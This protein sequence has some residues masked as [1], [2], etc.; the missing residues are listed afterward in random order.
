[1]TLRRRITVTVLGVVFVTLAAFATPLWVGYSRIY[2]DEEVLRLQRE[3][4][5]A[6]VTVPEELGSVPVE[7]P[8]PPEEITTA[9][10]DLEGQRVAGDGPTSGGSLVAQAARGEAVD[11]TSQ[12]ELVVAAPIYDDEEVIAVVRAAQPSHS[13]VEEV[14]EAR[15][16]ITVLGL[17]IVAGAAAVGIFLARRLARPVEALTAAATR[18]GDGDFATTA[19]HSGIRELDDAAQALDRTARRLG[20]IL[21]RERRFSADASHQLRTPLTGLRLALESTGVDGDV[22]RDEMIA[23]ALGHADRLETTIDEL[24]ALAR[25]IRPSDR[26]VDIRAVLDDLGKQWH[27]RFARQHRTL[28]VDVEPD[29]GSVP[30]SPSALHHAL[31]VLVT[32]ALDHGRGRVWVTAAPTAGGAVTIDVTDEG[33]GFADPDAAL[34]RNPDA[35]GHGI[36]L[37]L[38]ASLVEAEGGRLLITNPGPR[39]TVR[40]ILPRSSASA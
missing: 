13:V 26:T 40:M 32:N 35:T 6:A 28:H 1:M 5:R 7:L 17:V 8:T 36:G 23:A 30:V 25:D 16:G 22:D 15:V 21:D 29:V 4:Q 10:Y 2:H 33:L 11:G 37:S 9:V 12:G 38:A 14:T 18:L 27:E 31:D 34:A 3:A 39:P 24:L 20:D 19:P